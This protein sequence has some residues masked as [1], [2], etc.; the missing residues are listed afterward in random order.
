ML[1]PCKVF[2]LNWTKKFHMKHFCKVLSAASA[3]ELVGL[4]FG[5][6]LNPEIKDPA[7]SSGRGNEAN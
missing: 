2:G 3:L 7:P 1:H 4:K 5:S 6:L